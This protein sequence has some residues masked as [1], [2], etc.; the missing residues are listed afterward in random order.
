MSS[1]MRTMRILELLADNPRGLRV[2][3][4]ADRLAV[5]RA[6]PH[7]IL[8]DL[9]DSGYVVQDPETD[10]Y[11]CTFML[12]SVGLRQ[13]EAA[14]VNKWAR[15]ELESLAALSNELVRVCIETSGRLSFVAQ[16]QGAASALTIDSPLLAHIPLHATAL[17]KAF[18]ST[19]PDDEVVA[20]M[21]ERGMDQ[22]TPS[23]L[24]NPVNL[25]RELE[26]ARHQGFSVVQEEVELG[27]SAIA[28]PIVPPG[29]AEGRAVGAVSI[30]GPTVRLTLQRLQEY[31]PSLRRTADT[32]SRQWNVYTHFAQI[33][34]RV[35]G[36][37]IPELL[38]GL[39]R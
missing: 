35:E 3:D 34:P 2:T 22:Y 16:A 31:A 18:L 7:R 37:G 28:A 19:L 20:L 12:G 10:R 13:L 6:V 24:K 39:P 11:R 17:G 1:V 25:L 14:G 15:D 36:S 33:H 38:G 26:Q 8:A 21:E 32:L 4:L 23:T 5:N 29:S 9:V 27:I 30:A